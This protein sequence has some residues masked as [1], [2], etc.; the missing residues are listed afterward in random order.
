M[1]AMLTMSMGAEVKPKKEEELTFAGVEKLCVEEAS[2]GKT[3][4]I[5][6]LAGPV[7]L[8]LLCLAIVGLSIGRILAMRKPI[9]QVYQAGMAL[10]KT[11]LKIAVP[12]NIKESLHKL[13]PDVKDA[14][15]KRLTQENADEQA[16][17]RRARGEEE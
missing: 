9:D 11:T 1:L 7:V 8:N 10:T 6:L 17:Q 13:I 16:K 15:K 14:V 4:L 2:R 3:W 5:I 12:P